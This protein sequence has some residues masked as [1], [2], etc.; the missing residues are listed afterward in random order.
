MGFFDATSPIK[1]LRFCKVSFTIFYLALLIVVCFVS[2]FINL[3]D[4]IQFFPDHT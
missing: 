1:D 2:L 4:S 3:G